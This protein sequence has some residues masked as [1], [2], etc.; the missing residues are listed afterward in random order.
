[1]SKSEDINTLFRR[2]GGDA[3]S[4]QEIV[5]MSQAESAERHWSLLG[6]LK[7]NTAADIPAAQRTSDVGSRMAQVEVVIYKH[8]P[9][10]N[11]KT[12]AESIPINLDSEIDFPLVE[13]EPVPD[14]ELEVVAAHD[15]HVPKA[16]R[17]VTA[18]LDTVPSSTVADVPSDLRSMFDRI[19]APRGKTSVQPTSTNPLKRLIKW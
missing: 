9:E 17:L 13:E 1:M 14:V 12:A 16:I 2:F 3:D 18:P 4:Y 19:A 15:D 6:K 7:P 11:T 5:S 8:L 10:N